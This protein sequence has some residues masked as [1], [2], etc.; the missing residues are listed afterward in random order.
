M[1]FKL[2]E[3]L[4]SRSAHLF[5]KAGHSVETVLEE[6]FSGAADE[7]IFEACML[8]DRCLVSLDLAS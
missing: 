8:E 5:A 2:D 1:K 3:N 4:G 7:A 6:G